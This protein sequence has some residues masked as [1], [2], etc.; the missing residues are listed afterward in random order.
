MMGY[1]DCPKCGQEVDDIC[2][3][4]EFSLDGR[5]PTEKEELEYIISA[6]KWTE[7]ERTCYSCNHIWKPDFEGSLIQ[8][9]PNHT[10]IYLSHMPGYLEELLKEDCPLS[11][12][13]RE[14]AEEKIKKEN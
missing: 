12:H 14:L 10:R 8:N 2:M 4:F 3:D 1:I 5:N 7:E 6:K 13:F 11:N 9:S